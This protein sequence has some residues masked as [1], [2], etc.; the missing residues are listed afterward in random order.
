MRRLIRRLITPSLRMRLLTLV[1][2]AVV[3]AMA[4]TLYTAAERR[5][6]AA[7]GAKEDALRVARL[8]AGAQERF[9][10]GARQLLIFL[11]RLPEVRARDPK[12]CSALMAE[13][14]KQH[15]LYANFGVATAD[16]QILCSALP[17]AR[18]V[19]VADRAWF[20][21]AAQR[22][23]FAVGDYEMCPITGRTTLNFG[24]P[25][26]GE[27]GDLLGVIFAG[28]DWGW[29]KEVAGEARLPKGSTLKVFD[30]EGRILVRYPD[31]ENWAGRT[32][33]ET[34]VVKSVLLRGREGTAQG[35]GLDGVSRLYAFT[36]LRVGDTLA[37]LGGDEF[38]CIVEDVRDARE[39]G[40][41]A[42]KLIELLSQP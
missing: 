21:R 23:D 15:P 17:P 1:L 24:Y 42:D 33:R 16:G 20:R 11:A 39:A 13:L 36:H 2:L 26:L 8:A 18:P 5:E 10:E 9:V 19:S 28:L 27:T 37:R 7:R 31:P 40:V 32:A 35:I 4:L 14:Q 41:V 6:E 29:L 12:A 25:L 38:V 22:R 30:R 34:D 3:P